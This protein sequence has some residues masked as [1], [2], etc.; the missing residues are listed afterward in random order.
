[1]I[2]VPGRPFHDPAADS[3]LFESLLASIAPHVEV[4]DVAQDINHPSFGPAMADRLHALV[5]AAG[6]TAATP[7]GVT[8]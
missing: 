3:A 1:M 4:V 2:D 7:A 5:R 8:T 6:V